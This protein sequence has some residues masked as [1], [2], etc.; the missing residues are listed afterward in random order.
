MKITFS[1]KLQSKLKTAER[2]FATTW[3]QPCE[4]KLP[5]TVHKCIP[6]KN[7][8]KLHFT[9]YKVD[10]YH[11]LYLPWT[12]KDKQITSKKITLKK[13]NIELPELQAAILVFTLTQRAFLQK[14]RLQSGVDAVYTWCLSITA[15]GW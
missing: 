1:N 15:V 13:K 11:S 12:W 2:L 5:R 9:G 3:V 10:S 6:Y 8:K 14:A 7:S 4:P